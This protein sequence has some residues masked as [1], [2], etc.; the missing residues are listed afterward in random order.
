M[1][2]TDSIPA[3]AYLRRSTD[4]QEQSLGDQ[5]REIC[6]WAEQNDYDVITE[7]IDDARSGTSAETRPAFQKMIADAQDGGGFKAVIVWNSDRFSRGDVTETEHYRYLLRRAG[8]TVL[9]VTED[10]LDREGI[11]GDVLRTVKQF[12]NRQFSISLSRNTLRGQISSVL[13]ESDPGRPTPFGY[14]RVVTGPDGT[15]LYRVRFC[16]GCVREVFGK[17]GE[18]QATYTK[19]QSLRKPGKE[20]RAR[21]V[22]STDDRVQTVKDIYTMC[23]DGMGF[24][25]IAEALNKRGIPSAKGKLWSFTTIKALLENP[26]YKG[27]LVWNRRTEARFYKVKDGR[28]DKMRSRADSKKVTHHPEEDWIVIKDAVPAIVDRKSWQRAQQ[29][30]KKRRRCKGGAGRSR[31]RWLLSGLLRCGDCGNPYW[32]ERKGK[33]KAYGK[34]RVFNNYYSCS[35]RRKHGAVIC[36]PKTH[37]KADAIEGWVLEKLKGLVFGDSEGVEEAVERFLQAVAGDDDVGSSNAERIERDLKEIDATVTALTANIDPANM[38]LL[39][40]RLTELRKRKER[41]EEELRSAERA[42][43][44]IDKQELLQWAL[45][46][47]GGLADALDGRRGEKIRKAMSSYV[48]RIEL[49]PSDHTGVMVLTGPAHR[50][51]KEHDR[52]EGRSCVNVV[53]GAG[54]EPATFGL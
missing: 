35:G 15:M 48:D 50:L 24:K 49:K 13:A 21:L 25:A 6:R 17:D 44:R 45:E 11:D 52:P 40:G 23:L 18:L 32:G 41:L 42:H 34:K 38:A 3:A 1:I 39:N 26:T 12:Q 5:R 54:F 10:Y 33:G 4:R 47:I 20:C 30:V 43:A 14:D 53:A 9:S 36:S 31:N 27:D 28:A 19:G 7:Y 46:R 51:Y 22:L 37:I 8:V 16:P 2:S 29:M